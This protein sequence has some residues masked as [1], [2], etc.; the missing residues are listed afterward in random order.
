MHE[1]NRE[2]CKTEGVI[3][4][5][6]SLR[7]A[8]EWQE[9]R[10]CV[11]ITSSLR[12]SLR[13]KFQRSELPLRHHTHTQQLQLERNEAM[14]KVR[15]LENQLEYKQIHHRQL[16]QADQGLVKELGRK[17][18]E[19]GTLYQ[20]VQ[21]LDR[22]LQAGDET[23][24]YKMNAI[25]PHGKAIIIVNDSF[26]PNPLEP[27]LDLRPRRG[28]GRDML[29]FKQ[30]FENLGYLVETH[31]NLTSVQMYQVLI[32]AAQKNHEE[33]D[34]F[35]CCISTHGD[36]E[37]L[38]GVDSVGAKRSELIQLVKQSE[39]LHK[40]PKMFFIQACCTRPSSTPERDNWTNYQ[41][42]TPDQ[43]ADIFIANATTPN[44]ASFCDPLT[45]SLFVN[46]LHSVFTNHG[47]S[48]TLTALMHKVNREVCK[49][50][51]V[52]RKK[53]SLSQAAEWQEVRQCVAI[54]SSL[55]YSLQFKFQRSELPLRHHTHTQQ[56]QLERNEAMEKVRQLENQLEYKQIHHRELQ[57]AG[58]G[59]V[60]ELGRRNKEVGTLYQLVQKLD[61]Q[62]QA[63][64]G[65]EMYKMNAIPPHGK[66][67]IIVNDSFNPNPLEPNLDLRPCRGAGRD[68]FLF[69]QTFENLGYLVE[70]HSNL[71]SVQ[72]YQ[73]LIQAAQKNHEE[74]DSFVCC[75]STHGD[76]DWLYGVDSVG[77][78]RSE[79]IQLVKQSETLHKKPK[80]FFIQACRI[81]PSLTPSRD[82]WTN[83]QPNAPD[84]DADIFI[85]NATTPNSA[86]F[87]DLLTGSLFVNT[88]HSVFTSRGLSLTL[89]ALM[90]EVNREICKTEGMIREKDPLRQAA[91]WQEVRQFVAIT[92]SLRYSLRFK[93]SL[94]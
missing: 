74:Y 67:I 26:N 57:Q 16:Q 65:T 62:L 15:Q 42:N 37:K 60:E 34:S 59:L 36:E 87:H 47:P 85:A 78:K 44:S 2:V 94:E 4:E 39:T 28:A 54:T 27:N 9:V 79:L 6:D 88:I 75:I 7:Q 8:A 22:Q 33:Y 86:S 76:E 68:M 92:S 11:A 50:E 90:H 83:Y 1:V 70:A 77:A 46:T 58:R 52:I 19:V 21:R 3:R 41:P 13:F 64:D 40:K 53:D 80:M 84:Q 89:M 51:G 12:Y 31:P 93:F 55:R 71:T 25:L 32:Q 43:D 73:V 18:E 61:R 69:K 81:R 63:G 23:E 56:L 30:T 14:E 29:L 66:A 49:T 48:F 20:L 10:Q 35:V 91:G 24:M 45:G 82:N 17:N 38:Y 72:M 5:K